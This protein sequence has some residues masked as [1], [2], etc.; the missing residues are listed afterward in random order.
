MIRIVGT[1]ISGTTAGWTRVNRSIQAR[2]NMGGEALSQS[3]LRMFGSAAIAISVHRAAAVVSS[4]FRRRRV[5]GR[6]SR[7]ASRSSPHGRSGSRRRD[8]RRRL[9]GGAAASRERL[10]HVDGEP[11]WSASRRPR[12]TASCS[13]RRR[14]TRRRRERRSRGCA[15]R[16]ASTTTC[17]PF[18]ER[19]RDDPLIGPSVRARPVAARPPA[20]RAV[21]GARLGDH[22]AADR[23]R[24]RGGDPAADD[25]ARSAARCARTGLRDVPDAAHARRRR[26]RGAAVLRPQR[27]ARAG[28]AP[29]R[30]RGRGRAASTCARPT[31]SAAGGA[32]GAIPGIGTW[33]SRCSRCTGWAAT[34]SSPPA[35]SATSSSSA[36]CTHGQPAG[37]RRRRTRCASSSRP[38]ASG[39]ASRRVRLSRRRGARQPRP[40]PLAR[41]GTRWSAAR[42]AAGGRLSRLL[43]RI[44]RS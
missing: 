16:S 10:L 41:A 35:T 7:S 23:V 38:T 32:C 43:S 13:A 39:R 2:S 33:T 26:A 27:R 37:A 3:L 20:A 30:A 19:F 29:L 6:W 9:R 21:R 31:T 34:T 22:R 44:Q 15:S 18:Y 42:A 36:A 5:R 14:P 40:V 28:A 25:R 24:A 1:K 12:R 11:P 17:A 8:R 4:S